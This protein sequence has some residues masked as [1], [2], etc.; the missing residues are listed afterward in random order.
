MVEQVGSALGAAEGARAGAALLDAPQPGP[1]PALAR[2]RLK[3]AK[4]LVATKIFIEDQGKY[5]LY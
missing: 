2:A 1:P 5:S 3:A 4:Q